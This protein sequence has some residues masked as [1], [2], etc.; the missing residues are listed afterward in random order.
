MRNARTERLEYSAAPSLDPLRCWRVYL[1]AAGDL[2]LGVEARDAITWRTAA[3]HDTLAA[4]L[5]PRDSLAVSDL[6]LADHLRPMA[7]KPST[8]NDFDIAPNAARQF[9]R[10]QRMWIYYEIYDLTADPQ[11]YASYDVALTIAVKKLD[12]TGT[13]L[14]G[15]SNPLGILGLLADLWGFSV[16]GNDRIELRFS[17]AVQLDGRDRSTE[18]LSIDLF[19]A[20][21]GEYAIRLIVT[22]RLRGRN[23]SSDRLFTVVRSQ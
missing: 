3:V 13:F 11:G 4:R 14:G 22:D 15:K 16:V 7:R 9:A 20:P 17:R 19:D 23:A 6:L 18:H 1:P 8:R 21:P 12:R 10:N 2:I 5:F